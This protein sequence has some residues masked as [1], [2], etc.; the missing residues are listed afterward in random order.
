MYEVLPSLLPCHCLLSLVF[1]ILAAVTE[2]R[3]IHGKYKWDLVIFQTEKMPI[4]GD[5]RTQV[6]GKEKDVIL[7]VKG[8][9]GNRRLKK[10][11]G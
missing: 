4:R 3:W 1:L 6:T 8:L 5:C 7:V 9:S 2:V 10:R 11:R